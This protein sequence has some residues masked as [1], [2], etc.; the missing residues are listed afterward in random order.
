M[1]GQRGSTGSPPRAPS[2]GCR[3]DYADDEQATINDQRD[4]SGGRIIWSRQKN[5]R[6]LPEAGL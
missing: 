2:R 5:T 3:S 1:V 4:F 6:L